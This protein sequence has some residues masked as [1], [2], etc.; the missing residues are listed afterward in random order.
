MA[1][2][3]RGVSGSKHW[4]ASTG[5][6]C[7]KYVISASPKAMAQHYN[8]LPA[9]AIVAIQAAYGGDYLVS[10]NHYRFP[11]LYDTGT[12]RVYRLTGLSG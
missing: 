1:A 2:L 4:G 11:V 9:E 7:A 10:R 5:T 8:Q 3:T 6:R 12:Y